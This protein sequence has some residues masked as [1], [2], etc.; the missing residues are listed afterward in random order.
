MDNNKRKHEW[1][2]IVKLGQRDRPTDHRMAAV[3]K[4][5]FLLRLNGSLFPSFP[6]TESRRQTRTFWC[7]RVQEMGQPRWRPPTYIVRPRWDRLRICLSGRWKDAFNF[8]VMNVQ[9]GEWLC[10]TRRQSPLSLFLWQARGA[11]DALWW[12]GIC[13][14]Q[15][16]TLGGLRF[17]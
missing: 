17:E 4:E 6:S 1:N 15:F 3:I 7:A 14:A 13:G 2:V 11:K 9:W 5:S 10:Y 12:S 16:G 8:V